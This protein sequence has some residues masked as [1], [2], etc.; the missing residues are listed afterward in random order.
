MSDDTTF[1]YL[2][3]D[4][5][6]HEDCLFLNCEPRGDWHENP[7]WEGWDLL[8][9]RYASGELELSTEDS[10]GVFSFH[11][12]IS[13]GLALFFAGSRKKKIFRGLNPCALPPESKGTTHDT[14]ARH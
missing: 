11:P 13:Q 10:E 3:Y 9:T 14:A 7:R 4:N 12:A 6:T 1:C 8:I 5:K 2:L